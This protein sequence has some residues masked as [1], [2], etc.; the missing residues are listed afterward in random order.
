MSERFDLSDPA[1]Y[2]AGIEAANEAIS[3]GELIVLPT[4]TVYGVGADAFDPDPAQ[5]RERVK[6]RRRRERAEKQS[7]TDAVY[8]GL[9]ASSWL[10]PWTV[11]GE[12]LDVPALAGTLLG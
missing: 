1:Q 12:A 3:K 8:R 10:S 2:A 7:R 6:E 5:R 9:A 4:D 11:L